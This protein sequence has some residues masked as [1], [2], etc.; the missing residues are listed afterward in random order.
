MASEVARKR[1]TLKGRL[2]VLKGLIS[3]NEVDPLNASIR[4]ERVTDLFREYES[5]V[6]GLVNEEG[7]LEADQ[8]RIV[9]NEYYEM[10]TRIRTLMI[11]N[12]SNPGTSS[13]FGIPVGNSTMIERQQLVKLPIA[14]LPQFDG[15][16]EKWLSFKNT[17]L[18]MIDARTD[19]DDLNKFLYLRDCLKG[20]AFNKLALYDAS[21]ENYARAWKTLTDEY[22][23]RRVLIAKHYDGIIDIPSLT[24]ASS[25]GLTRIIDDARQ[26]IS[27]LESLK[28]KIDKGMIVRT[29]EKKLPIDVRMKWEETL[30]F[31]EFPTFEQLCKFI[32]EYVFRINSLNTNSVQRNASFNNKRRNEHPHNNSS[33]T[34]KIDSVAKTFVTSFQNNC[35]YCKNAHPIYK[36]EEFEKLKVQQRWEVV[37]SKKLCRNCLRTHTGPCSLSHCKLCDRFHNTLLHDESVRSNSTR[38]RKSN[39]TNANSPNSSNEDA[40]L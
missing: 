35:A 38:A 25:E 36:C 30:S 31:D 26:H 4:F 16:H 12:S 28:V 20:S 1:G 6:E 9:E 11:P 39:N 22:E 37:K 17:F 19:V 23:K 18:S 33:K 21:A 14:N 10:A 3:N 5:L 13:S 34:R 7:N 29:I 32:S 24:V 40:S 8:A 27:M 2:T 15:N